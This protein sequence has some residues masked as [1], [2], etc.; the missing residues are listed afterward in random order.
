MKIIMLILG[1]LISMLSS[2]ITYFCQ[3]K[4]S[5]I[6]A[7]KGEVKI[8]ARITPI[9]FQLYTNEISSWCTLPITIEIYNTKSI[10]QIIR[11]MKVAYYSKGQFIDNAIQ[12]ISF[13][14]EDET[15]IFGNN[16]SYS[17]LVQANEIKTYRLLFKGYEN[18][19]NGEEFDE[20]RLS[21]FDSKDE[22]KEC[23]LLKYDK[24]SKEP[25]NLNWKWHKV[26]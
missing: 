1:G 17:F 18:Y 15:H 12:V 19:T 4:F 16:G 2:L 9:N 14:E 20:I 10:N 22:K 13:R 5:D 7:S 3:Q 8:Y 24:E 25:Y 6:R 21:Y 26:F 11:D 23:S